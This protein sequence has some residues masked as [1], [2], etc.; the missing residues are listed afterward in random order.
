MHGGAEMRTS[1]AFDELNRIRRGVVPS[2]VNEIDAVYHRAAATGVIHG[3]DEPNRRL[4]CI[5]TTGSNVHDDF[6]R[7]TPQSDRAP[8]R[9]SSN[10]EQDNEHRDDDVTSSLP[11]AAHGYFRHPVRPL[12]HGLA[13][14][15]PT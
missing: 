8:D 5:S 6:Q 4:T 1:P 2:P 15:S 9:S 11:T 14:R 13:E 12:G 3:E 7:A 10:G